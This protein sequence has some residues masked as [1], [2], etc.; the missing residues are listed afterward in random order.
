MHE[1]LLALP[2]EFAVAI[3]QLGGDYSGTG[4]ELRDDHGSFAICFRT[5]KLDR[6]AIGH[7]I[8]HLQF[9]IWHYIDED[10]PGKECRGY[11]VGWLTK[12]VCAVLGRHGVAI[13][14]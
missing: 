6:D 5:D 14:D 12:E 13:F 2:K 10:A 8:E 3:A 4:M 9:D 7:E 11:L 1:A